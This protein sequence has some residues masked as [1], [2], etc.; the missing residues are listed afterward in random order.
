MGG[1][2]LSKAEDAMTDLRNV[3]ALLQDA[4]VLLT[5]SGFPLAAEALRDNLRGIREAPTAGARRHRI[6]QLRDLFEGFGSAPDVYFCAP[7]PGSQGFRFTRTEA[8]RRDEQRYRRTLASIQ[9]ILATAR[10]A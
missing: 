4:I 1:A 5:E 3:E 6:F 10:V 7:S 8:H 9:E 2:H